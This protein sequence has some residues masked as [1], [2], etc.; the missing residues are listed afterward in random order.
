MSTFSEKFESRLFM[1]FLLLLVWLPLPL[2]SDRPWAE[3][4]F[5]VWTSLLALAYLAGLRRGLV[6]PGT[7]FEHARPV[8][9]LLVA[10]LA[11]LALQWLPI[12]EAA[13]VP[14]SLD[15]FT[16]FAYWLKSL[17]YVVLFALTLL[18]VNS[19]L[20]LAMLGYALVFSGLFQ[21]FYGGVMTLSGLEYGFFVP[22]EFYR[23]T[24]TGTFVNRNHLAGYLEMTLATGIGL[25]LATQ[26]Q[27]EQAL[28]WRQHLRN[29]LN[30]VFSQKLPL[31][32]MLAVMVI[33]LVLS[34]SRMGNTAFFSSMLVAGLAALLIYRWQAGSLSGMLRRDDMR[35]AVILIASLVVIDILIVGAWFGV[36]KVAERIANSSLSND[37]DRID[38]SRD[39]LGL[40]ADHPI[41]G[42]GGG[43]FH[44]AFMP[45]RSQEVAAYYDHAHQDYLEIAADTGLVGMGL[46]GLV[47]LTSLL[48][49]LKA[50]ARRRDALMRGM[51]FA[52]IMGTVAL[53]IHATVDFNFHIP[54]NAATFM[55]ILAMG[56]IALHL[57][58]QGRG[59]HER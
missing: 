47:V 46:L 40:I 33:A 51:A 34:R 43:S 16:T 11:W 9:W 31:R 12:Q 4:I 57:D 5:I 42:T 7:A 15:P 48:A 19:K 28:S 38:V 45:Y 17:G 58:R 44:L 52:S 30:L 21:A 24:A 20:R 6:Q 56:W 13:W 32:L 26:Y 25:L 2:G 23:G 50:F 39:T 22:K 41:A 37:A 27:R 53:L 8:L 59:T 55:T 18:L 10:W 36:E 29:L 54:A 3:A 49:A 1:A 14:L 35:S